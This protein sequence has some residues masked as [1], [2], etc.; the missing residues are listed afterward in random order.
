MRTWIFGLVFLAPPWLKKIL[1]RW[2]CRAKIGPHARIGWFSSIVARNIELGEHS[3]IQPLTLIRL[4]GD[5]TVGAYSEIS[6]FNLIYGSSSLRI[7]AQSY[8][9]PQ[10][11]INV[12]EPVYIGDGSAL[13]PRSLVFTHGS[14]LPYTEGYWAR[15]AGVTLGNQ[16]W[17]AAGVFLQPGVEIGDETFVNSM[18]VVSG[19]IPPGS[20]VEGNPARVIYPIERVK[21][22]MTPQ[23]VDAALRQILHD[24]SQV[25]LRREWNVEPHE[26]QAA[27]SFCWRGQRYNIQLVGAETPSASQPLPDVR[28]IYLVNHPEWKIPPH[29]LYFD[30][31]TRQTIYTSDKVHTALRL[32]MQRYYGL[33][34]VDRG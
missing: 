1:L 12:D 33:K 27:L 17:C 14:F 18:S 6:S 29:A 7:G 13:G 2:L 26:A 34:F 16:V 20:V 28:Y 9:G 19:V 10:V 11:M 32:F 8:I 31:C 5:L 30:V 25:V 22:K 15:R 24:F 3:V 21:R 4:S 23:R